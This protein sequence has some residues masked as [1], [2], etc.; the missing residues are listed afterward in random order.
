M[1]KRNIITL[2][3]IMLSSSFLFTQ[4]KFDTNFESGSLGSYKL[5]DSA[6]IAVPF[7]DS[8]TILNYNI[9]SRF[10][11]KNPVDTSLSPSARWYYFRM[12]GVKNKLIYLNVYNSEAIRP[13]YSYDNVNFER[14]S[15]D[16]NSRKNRVIKL[17]ERDTVYICHYIP[18]TYSR[19]NEKVKEWSGKDFVKTKIIGYSHDS[20]AIPMLRI[21][22][23]KVKDKNKKIV[24]IHGRSHPSESPANW[25]LEGMLNNLLADNQFAADIRKSAIFYVVPFINPDGVYGG[26]SRSSSTGVNLEINWDR[27]DSLTM[28]EVKVLK[29][30]IDSIT[31]VHKIDLFLNMHSQIANSATYWIHKAQGTTSAFYTKQLLLSNLT[32]NDNPY[33][34]SADQLF[35]DVAPRYAEGWMWNKFGERT[36]AITFE[37]PYTYYRE[38]KDGE[39]VSIENLAK[40]GLSSLNAVCDWLELPLKDRMVLNRN[41][42]YSRRDFEKVKS[43]DFVTFGNTFY[44]AKKEGATFEFIS[45][46]LSAGKYGLYKWVAGPSDTVSPE[47]TNCWV[48]IK[49]LTNEKTG[50]IKIKLQSSAAKEIFDSIL[51]KKLE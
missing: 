10:D 5:T 2:L 39:W 18:Y 49:D 28:P 16:E 33:Y 20:L 51:L 14:F 17:F 1:L 4:V 29:R 15:S 50:K 3:F 7:M 22:D 11:P 38:N 45:P 46:K 40:F 37:T 6:K 36:L 21:T 30:T 48:L 47:G 24:W 13:F 44:S 41:V 32:A 26:Y 12:T 42:K 35:S 34:S 43:T 23:P 9:Y 8:L 31:K 27:P 25:H 19:M